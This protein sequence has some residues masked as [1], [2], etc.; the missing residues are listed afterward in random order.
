MQTVEIIKQALVEALATLGIEVTL[1]SVVLE[2]PAELINGDY[3]T[4]AALAYAKLKAMAPR[5]LAEDI[6]R[7]LGTVEGVSKIDI[8]GPG[9]V[10]FHLAPEAVAKTLDVARTTDTWGS[11]AVRAG[12][13]IMVEYTQ[14]NPFKE[15][16]IGHLMSNALGESV[17][18][19]LQFSGAKVLRANYQG[20]VGLH[21]AKA[22]WGY[23][24]LVVD[25]SQGDGTLTEIARWGMAYRFGTAQYENSEENKKAIDALG[26]EIY[27]H[28]DTIPEY[29]A[30][31]ALSLKHFEELY[32]ILGTTFDY[33]FFESETGPMGVEIVKAHPEVFEESEGATVFKAEQYGLHTRVFLNRLGLPTYEAKDLGLAQLKTQRAT[34]DTS[35]TITA[36]EQSEYFKVVKKAM[37]LIFPEIAKKVVHVSHGMMRFADGKMS[38]RTGNVITGESLLHDLIDSANLRAQESRAL[39]KNKL[40]QD[41]AVAAIKYQVLRQASGKNIVFDRERALSL[42]GDSG[43]YLEYSLART[44]AVVERAMIEGVAPMLDTSAP[45]TDVMRLVC[46]FPEVVQR[47]AHELEPHYLAQYLLLVA[48]GFNSWYAQEQILDGT[49]S[50]AHKVAVVAAVQ[51]TLKNGLWMLGI[52]TPDKM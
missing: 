34:F 19:L 45:L 16:H 4:S 14:P 48:A 10:N 37:E 1:D 38:S 43:P 26:Q 21:V 15:F 30:G 12:E 5:V 22:I 20:D 52:P 24:N 35:I 9:F 27:A 2:H 51:R 41:I 23:R 33:Y 18:R 46:R 13:T 44:N 7:A 42:E 3:S 11:N 49:P 6:V 40:A 32:A 39:D 29:V 31:R 25:A 17:A 36:Q 47:A 50:A 8:A 28:A